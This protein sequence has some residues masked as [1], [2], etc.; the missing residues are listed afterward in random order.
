[1]SCYCSGIRVTPVPDR[2]VNDLR[3]NF[4]V[5]LCIVTLN[6]SC[7]RFDFFWAHSVLRTAQ[8]IYT[9][10]KHQAPLVSELSTLEGMR[11]TITVSSTKLFMWFD[12]INNSSK[13]SRK[14]SHHSPI[15]LTLISY[16]K[17]RPILSAT[18]TFFVPFT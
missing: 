6:S 12:N 13:V 15:I 1:M 17:S 3:Y 9:M 14:L 18:I 8:R 2:F 5:R 16:P 10:V 7:N 11:Y 4:V